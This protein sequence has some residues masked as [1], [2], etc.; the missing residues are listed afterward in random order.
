M[1]SNLLLWVT[2]CL[3]LKPI[4]TLLLGI[5]SL[6]GLLRLSVALGRLLL[7]P[8]LIKEVKR[9]VARLKVVKVKV[10]TRAKEREELKQLL[11]KTKWTSLVMILR[12]TLLLRKP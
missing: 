10:K 11:R 7:L 3:M 2:M 1:L 12:L 6:P 9:K 4:Q 5:C 8:L